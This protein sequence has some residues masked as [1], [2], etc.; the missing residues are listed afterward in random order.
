MSQGTHQWCTE[1]LTAQLIHVCE[2]CG[3]YRQWDQNCIAFVK[4]T[5]GTLV[6]EGPNPNYQ[7]G[8]TTDY[9]NMKLLVNQVNQDYT[10]LILD[11]AGDESVKEVRRGE[12]RMGALGRGGGG[13]PSSYHLRLL[14]EAVLTRCFLPPNVYQ[15][16]IVC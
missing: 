5:L 8:A 16:N 12:P 4:Q 6:S 11:L 3:D 13:Q 14:F 7:Y 2:K 9:N 1:S 10:V 15:P